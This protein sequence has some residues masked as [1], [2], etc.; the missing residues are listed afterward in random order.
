MDNNTNNNNK[1]QRCARCGAFLPKQGGAVVH[2]TNVQVVQYCTDCTMLHTIRCSVCSSLHPADYIACPAGGL[3]DYRATPAGGWQPLS[4]AARV[5]LGVELEV[6]DGENSAAARAAFAKAVAA[7]DPR[8]V[9]VKRDGSLRNA[10][11]ELVT[12]PASLQQHVN[13]KEAYRQ[14]FE[15]LIAGGLKGHDSSCAGLHV[16]VNRS[17]TNRWSA[18]ERLIN[19]NA[20]WWSRFARRSNSTYAQ[21]ETRPDYNRWGTPADNRYRVVNFRNSD[22]VEFR[23]FRSTLKVETFLATLQAVEALVTYADTHIRHTHAGYRRFV[24]NNRIDLHNY[25][26]EKGL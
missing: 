12:Q 4:A 6:S 26:T 25:L 21:Y 19:T 24:K 13:R 11:G 8:F 10:S 3:K 14:A 22:T 18:V 7:L 2:L 5:L 9:M 16:H 20:D 15:D 1:R 23:L 17:A